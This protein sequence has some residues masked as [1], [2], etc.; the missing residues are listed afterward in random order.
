M[1]EI[2]LLEF[3]SDYKRLSRDEVCTQKIEHDQIAVWVKS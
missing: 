2:A 3:L 1:D